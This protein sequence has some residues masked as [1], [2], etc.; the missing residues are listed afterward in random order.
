MY[1]NTLPDVFFVQLTSAAAAA[2]FPT[3]LSAS[4]LISAS[5]FFIKKLK[6]SAEI[7]RRFGQNGRE[8]PAG[9]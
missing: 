6:Y 3:S 2:H 8:R 7:E 5:V 9:K 4:L 1:F